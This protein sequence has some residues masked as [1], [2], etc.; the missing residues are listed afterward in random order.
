MQSSSQQY[1]RLDVLNPLEHLTV[2]TATL[3]DS[4]KHLG[5]SLRELRKFT[6]LPFR[7]IVSDDGSSNPDDQMRQRSVCEPN[8]AEWIQ[9]PGPVYGISY[10]LNWLCENVRTPW[11][12]VIEDSVR[13]SMG[14]LE[15]AC[16]ALER[17]GYRKWNG[18][19]VGAIG[20][21]TS[22]EA[23]HLACANVIP[24]ELGLEGFF[25]QNGDTQHDCFYGSEFHNGD[26]NTGYI[27]WQAMHD[28]C[29]KTC[30]I[31]GHGDKWPEIIRRTWRDPILRG[32]IGCMRWAQIQGNWGWQAL[33]GWPRTR[34]ASWAMGPSAWMLLN[35]DA[36][37]D[38]GRFRDGCTFYEGHLGLRMAKKGYLCINCECPPWLHMSGLAF[39]I[40]DHQKTPRHH[41]HP[42]GPD[43]I[44]E[45]DFGCNGV[46]HVDL[47]ALAR[48]YFEPGELD[49]LS[50]QLTPITLH[51]E[52]GWKQW[53]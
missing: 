40:K 18:R 5:V 43:G 31:P 19:T 41:E 34:G 11:A 21:T 17:I 8:G 46:D 48:S 10:N 9:N 20:M 1:W 42:D 4:Y 14:W 28:Q 51:M 2:V 27:C 13:P 50:R 35:L 52:E 36:W 33:S 38:V 25:D 15:T 12:F 45:R 7:Q 44:L 24:C 23:W 3:G 29:L 32:E 53:A 37:R 30:Q 22:F 47:A 39:R 49:D 26:W 16:D 6:K